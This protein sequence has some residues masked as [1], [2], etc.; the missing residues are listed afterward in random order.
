MQSSVSLSTLCS[1]WESTHSQ[2]Q[3]L[4]NI[5]H[6]YLSP[7]QLMAGNVAPPMEYNFANAANSMLE[8]KGRRVVEQEHTV[9]RNL[10]L[11]GIGLAIIFILGIV[12]L[13]TCFRRRKVLV[14]EQDLEEGSIAIENVCYAAPQDSPPAY[15]EV[16]DM[17][18][19]SFDPPPDYTEVME[20]Q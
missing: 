5:C 1:W 18:H 8:N 10:G 19:Q 13:V 14:N 6:G 12:S 16:A 4:P 17:H 7:E 2:S 20:I 9:G 11:A 3:A 15:E